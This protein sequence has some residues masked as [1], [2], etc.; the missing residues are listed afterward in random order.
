MLK[1]LIMLKKVLVSVYYL[2][3]VIRLAELTAYPGRMRG[4][5]RLW[6]AATSVDS[7]TVLYMST[8]EDIRQR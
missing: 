7:P 1:K 6:G 8:P 3:L 4:T 5:G 2:L